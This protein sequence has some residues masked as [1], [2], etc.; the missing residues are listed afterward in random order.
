MCSL[1][2]LVVDFTWTRW[3]CERSWR[4]D[5]LDLTLL[6]ELRA[7]SLIETVDTA[8]KKKEK[9]PISDC[10]IICWLNSTQLAEST[11]LTWVDVWMMV[12]EPEWNL[13]R[14]GDEF[15]S[16]TSTD[17][18]SRVN[19]HLP[20]DFEGFTPRCIEW[21]ELL[22]RANKYQWLDDSFDLTQL[23]VSMRLTWWWNLKRTSKCGNLWWVREKKYREVNFNSY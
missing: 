19:L 12:L 20:L 4:L 18:A 5:R 13:Q 6:A 7:H 21:F 23:A 22:R 3:A 17:S 2:L 14:K 9:A 1:T 16:L 15:D 8:G 11:R 10:S